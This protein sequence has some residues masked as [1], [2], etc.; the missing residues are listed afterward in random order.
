MATAGSLPLVLGRVQEVEGTAGEAPTSVTKVSM[1]HFYAPAPALC[2][3]LVCKYHNLNNSVSLYKRHITVHD[4][5]CTGITKIAQVTAWG[6]KLLDL[7]TSRSSGEQRGKSK[8]VAV[9]HRL[10]CL[11]KTSTQAPYL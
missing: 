7:W 8:Q 1:Q 4:E 2:D 11:L 9:H 10:S 3:Y 6:P 5:T